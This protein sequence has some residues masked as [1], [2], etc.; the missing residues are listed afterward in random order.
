MLEKK[1]RKKICTLI[2][3]FQPLR[4]VNVKNRPFQ[5]TQRPRKPPS[6]EIQCSDIKI[7]IFSNLDP[8]PFISTP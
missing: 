7:S 4:V 2:T 6:N 3:L 8:Q 5:S 1:L